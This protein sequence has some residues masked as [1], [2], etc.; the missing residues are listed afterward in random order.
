MSICDLQYDTRLFIV[1]YSVVL[2]CH[3]AVYISK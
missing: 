3:V 1:Q 2:V